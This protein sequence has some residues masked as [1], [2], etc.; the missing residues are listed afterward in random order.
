MLP[1][2][3]HD[4]SA[5]VAAGTE[6][7]ISIRN[8]RTVFGARVI[9]D[10]IDLDVYRGEVL[11]L[12]GGSGSGKSTL[13]REMIMLQ[14]PDAGSIQL[15]GTD[16][17]GISTAGAQQLRRRF[18]V[19]VRALTVDNGYLSA[20]AMENAARVCAAVDVEHVVIRPRP[21]RLREAFRG[22]VYAVASG[23]YDICL[24]LGDGIQHL[25][26][27]V[28]LNTVLKAEFGSNIIPKKNT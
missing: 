1:D 16:V 18:G 13:L 2:M 10:G 20:T 26:E 5:P 17:V 28:L 24:A 7:V 19:A 15:F 23:A 6:A 8:L 14:E 21:E 4:T 12:V 22:A 27:S 25:F 11:A 9:H 3:L